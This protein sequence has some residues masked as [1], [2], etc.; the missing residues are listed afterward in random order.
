MLMYWL[1]KLLIH[2]LLN[3]KMKKKIFYIK[4]LHQ[5]LFIMHLY[6]AFKVVMQV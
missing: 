2:E 3:Q 4:T 6:H 1:L 5:K